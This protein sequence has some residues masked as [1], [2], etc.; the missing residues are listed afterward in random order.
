MFLYSSED[1]A[2]SSFLFEALFDR[3]CVNVTLNNSTHIFWSL[4]ESIG[5][6]KYMKE[7]LLTEKEMVFLVLLYFYDVPVKILK[8][9]ADIFADY[10]CGFFNES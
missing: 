9:N 3:W 5:I 1:K 2:V 10:I 4:V 7:T 8:D 6:I